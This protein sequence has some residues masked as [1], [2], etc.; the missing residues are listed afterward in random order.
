[1]LS[2]G[3]AFLI[4]DS[5]G[6]KHIFIVISDPQANP[7]QIVLVP[8]TSWEDYKDDT[9]VL[10]PDDCPD[11][12]FVTHTSC[13]DFQES[14]LTSE[15]VLTELVAGGKAKKRKRWSSDLIQKIRT[16]AAESQRI[17]NRCLMVLQTQ[18]LL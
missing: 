11:E 10:E 7:H 13:I 1:M 2:P 15:A 14:L 9:C 18:N 16:R 12:P 8:L 5:H 4:P 3:D 6:G 17:P